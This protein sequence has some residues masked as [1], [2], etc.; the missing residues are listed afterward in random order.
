M[1]ILVKGEEGAISE[2]KKGLE[3]AA[4]ELSKNR[5]EFCLGRNETS[6]KMAALLTLPKRDGPSRR[7]K[8]LT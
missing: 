4:V 5:T 8:V 2:S 3:A 7:K 6:D 1:I